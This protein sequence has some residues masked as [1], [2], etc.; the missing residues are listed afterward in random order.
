MSLLGTELGR[1]RIVSL[2][3][4]ISYTLLLFVAV[5]LKY[6]AHEPAM[7]RVLGRVHGGLFVLFL[8]ALFR[9]A[10]GVP[11][12]ARKVTVAFLAAVVP[13]GAFWLERRLRHEGA[14]R[15]GAS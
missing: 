4:G 13:L 14:G 10:V 15:T 1:L 6:L 11:W 3:E 7:V 5:P 9:V 8:L 12:G 2:L